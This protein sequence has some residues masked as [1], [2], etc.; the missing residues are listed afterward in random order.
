MTVWLRSLG[1][2]PYDE[3]LGSSTGRGA[4]SRGQPAP[5]TL[6]ML[7]P[8]GEE[9]EEDPRVD[10]LRKRFGSVDKPK[11]RKKNPL[12]SSRYPTRDVLSEEAT[13]KL[14]PDERRK[15]NAELSKIGFD[16][17]V[18]FQSIDRALDRI[19]RVMAKY[20]VEWGDTDVPVEW[21]D[22]QG[23][24]GVYL[25]RTGT[26]DSAD[27]KVFANTMAFVQWVEMT[28]GL[29]VIAHLS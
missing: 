20:G 14:T 9:P 10:E 7:P 26:A 19:G 25:A 4:S 3:D 13:E 6:Q 11:K 21:R 15:I 1:R 24:V 8:E 18:R 27:P 22:V 29:E 2:L 5:K 23:S 16:G 17:T 28:D 12:I